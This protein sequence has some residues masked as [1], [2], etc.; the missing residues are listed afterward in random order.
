MRKRSQPAA[1]QA[2]PCSTH[3][4]LDFGFHQ[5]HVALSMGPG[6][7]RSNS[8]ERLI[9]FADLFYIYYLLD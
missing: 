4:N 1:S 8:Y 6:I 3:Y 2:T 5:Q 9:D 7:D